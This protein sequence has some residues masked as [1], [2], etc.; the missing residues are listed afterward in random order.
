MN[1]PEAIALYQF[2]RGPRPGDADEQGWIEWASEWSRLHRE[3]YAACKRDVVLGF[4][5]ADAMDS[6]WTYAIHFTPD[7]DHFEGNIGAQIAKR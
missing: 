1:Y 5:M 4:S 2:E 3:W 6:S 7:P